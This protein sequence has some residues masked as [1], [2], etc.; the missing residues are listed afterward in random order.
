MRSLTTGEWNVV[1]EDAM[2][3]AAAAVEQTLAEK[4]GL[5]A[6]ALD[7]VLRSAVMSRQIY[8]AFVMAG[9]PAN[10][11]YTLMSKTMRGELS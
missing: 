9:W 2:A 6:E 5:D 3:E 11:A 10:V 4:Y 7:A 1:A 8:N